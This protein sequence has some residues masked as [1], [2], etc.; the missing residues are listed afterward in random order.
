MIPKITYNRER[1][2]IEIIKIARTKD[3]TCLLQTVRNRGLLGT[4]A[5]CFACRMLLILRLIYAQ[6]LRAVEIG[7]D[8]K[9]VTITFALPGLQ[10]TGR[11][12]STM[13]IITNR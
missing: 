10:L 11:S 6:Q 12:S 8:R 1:T 9:F 3:R 5:Y 4:A 13:V 7:I 2:G